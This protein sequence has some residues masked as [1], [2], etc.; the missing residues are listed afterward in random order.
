MEI[1]NKKFWDGVLV[2]LIE[3]SISVKVWT[4]FS[5]LLISTF[6]LINGYISD[7]IWGS[8]NSGIIA[9]VFALRESFKIARV[10]IKEKVKNTKEEFV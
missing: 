5:V 4:I 1:L 3:T 2:K 7:T 6:L 8:V 10:N 9:T